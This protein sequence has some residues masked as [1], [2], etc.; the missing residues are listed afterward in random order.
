VSYTDK[1]II[2]AV[3]EQLRF[4]AECVRKIHE[5]IAR[6]KELRVRELATKVVA[7]H[8]ASLSNVEFEQ[9]VQEC[10]TLIDAQEPRSAT[11]VVNEIQL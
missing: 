2:D 6:G 11:I 9:L 5:T 4:D 8:G 1:E 10:I 7:D 3:N